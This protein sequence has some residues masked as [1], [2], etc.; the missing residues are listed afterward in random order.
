MRLTLRSKLSDRVR[1]F[2]TTNEF[3][4]FTDLSYKSASLRPA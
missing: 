3:V 1:H 2:M 4:C